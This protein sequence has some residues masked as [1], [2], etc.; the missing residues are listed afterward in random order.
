[1][2]ATAEP[3]AFVLAELSEE[4]I[5]EFPHPDIVRKYLET[6]SDKTGVQILATDFNVLGMKGSWLSVSRAHSFLI[7]FLTTY[8]STELGESPTKTLETDGPG[9][10]KLS[11][12]SDDDVGDYEQSNT[13]CVTFESKE[14]SD[15][16][17]V[18]NWLRWTAEVL[19]QIQRTRA[20]RTNDSPAKAT[21]QKIPEPFVLFANFQPPSD[22][23]AK[24]LPNLSDIERVLKKV[25]EKDK[26]DGSSMT[27][28]DLQNSCSKGT[29]ENEKKESV[30]P[31]SANRGQ[32]TDQQLGDSLDKD[33]AEVISKS[34]NSQI[35]SGFSSDVSSSAL[36]EYPQQGSS[37][38]SDTNKLMGFSQVVD[39]L[40]AQD[41]PSLDC[42]HTYKA[43]ED[44]ISS[45]Y[46]DAV[47][48]KTHADEL[49]NLTS[50]RAASEEREQIT[51][52]TVNQKA[53]RKGRAKK[54]RKQKE[55]K[56]VKSKTTSLD[57]KTARAERAAKREAKTCLS[58]SSDLGSE[59][60]QRI[61][62]KFSAESEYIPRKRKR[63]RPP[64]HKSDTEDER[65]YTCTE[66]PYVAKKRSH[67][68]EHKRRVHITKEFKC[69]KCGKIFGYGK[70][71]KRHCK[72]HQRAENCCDI[73]G[74]M[75]K[76]FRSLA[77]HKKTHADGYIKPTFPCEFCAKNFSTK[78]VLAYH[79]RSEHLG[80]K[81]T[82][83][84]PTCGKSFSQKNSY[85]QHANVHM[86][87]RPHQCDV[88][89][90]SFSY[91]KSL[92]EHKYMHDE[93]KQFACPICHKKFRQ[94]SGVTIHMKIHKE[95]KDYVCAACGKGFS[96][97]QALVR[98]E[99]IHG[100]EKPFTCG[101]CQR[102][103]TDSSILRRHMILIHK[104]DPKK[105]REDTISNVTRRTDFF[106]SVLEENGD[107]SNHDA[108]VV[109][110]HVLPNALPASDSE[111][112]SNLQSKTEDNSFDF[113]PV[114]I[115]D[116]SL[117]QPASD[118]VQVNAT[119]LQMVYDGDSNLANGC[120]PQLVEV[121]Q[122]QVVPMAQASGTEGPSTSLPVPF[123]PRPS[124]SLASQQLPTSET[125]VQ[126]L[127]MSAQGQGQVSVQG[128]SQLQTQNTSIL[129]QFAFGDNHHRLSASD[130]YT[131]DVI[132]GIPSGLP[133]QY[134]GLLNP[135]VSVTGTYHPPV[136][137]MP[138]G[139]NT[140]SF[141]PG[142]L[143][144]STSSPSETAEYEQLTA[145]P[146]MQESPDTHP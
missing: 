20:K 26:S 4:Y 51:A 108:T 134:P 55:A 54:K 80:M 121:N 73:C 78:Y 138:D 103:F 123:E 99:R 127:D 17:G 6:V 113:V 75:Y 58:M 59:T 69:D 31:Q 45:V 143:S 30:D 140:V 13:T 96:Q 25:Y 90:K 50:T 14:E 102:T 37:S 129:T 137:V 49:N 60:K 95:H 40:P 106:I 7:E 85:L 94:T 9:K 3:F 89:G 28:D 74:K 5:G 66:C 115:E 44:R 104:K 120:L 101:L 18:S 77:E 86:G 19:P 142:P 91:E 79:I 34:A 116:S 41:F 114:G 126:P 145:H 70:D 98:H 24:R 84:C 144:V 2:A 122:P 61:S 130:F 46:S 135:T 109:K 33:V 27:L 65:D 105:W 23:T 136:V 63:G 141:L 68:R 97:K 10:T 71:L 47:E 38:T 16:G 22:P 15:C 125:T 32:I 131:A 83:I 21:V 11:F 43:E 56:A 87:I 62:N 39:D 92:K 53:K 117:Q 81:K 42:V 64:L 82:Y 35:N 8:R 128:H 110:S 133:L 112:V 100:G 36:I 107:G 132:Q 57:R 48:Q 29:E 72:T 1:M 52:A 12:S 93:N 76:G 124:P 118:S 111:N 146:S 119:G 67:L 88:C 139:L